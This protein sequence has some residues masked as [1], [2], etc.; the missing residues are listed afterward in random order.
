V[1][2]LPQNSTVARRSHGGK[3]RWLWLLLLPLAMALATLGMISSARRQQKASASVNPVIEPAAVSA[4]GLVE[5]NGGV[6]VVNAPYY[7]NGPAIVRELKVREGDWVR[8]GQVL[9]VMDS[10]PL[11]EAALRQAQARVQAAISR[12]AQIKAAP[13]SADV[14]A[15][16]QQ[17]ASAQASLENA[18]IQDRRYHD[19]RR[20]GLVAADAAEEKRLAVTTLERTIDEITNRIRSLSEVRQSDVDVAQADLAAARADEEL[21]RRELATTDVRAPFAGRILTLCA[22][23]GEEVGPRGVLELARTSEMFVIAEVYERDIGRVRVGQQAEISGEALGQPVPGRVERIDSSVASSEVLPSDPS[24]FDDQR[25][26][27]VHVRADDGRSLENVI[28]TRVT[29]VFRP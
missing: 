26:I 21:A 24:A 29:V 28:H 25:L 3:A 17:R 11:Q 18:R 5:P 19:L 1:P 7:A 10:Q 8:S 27:K 2:E 23:A 16:E 22:H 4:L 6:V 9:A 14:A 12:L 15:L 13:K 20:E